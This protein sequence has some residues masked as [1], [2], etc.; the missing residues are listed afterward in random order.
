LEEDAQGQRYEAAAYYYFSRLLAD[1]RSQ[2]G[3]AHTAFVEAFLQRHTAS[4][5]ESSAPSRHDSAMQEALKAVT[6]LCKSIEVV[7]GGDQGA[8]AIETLQ[9]WLHSSVERCVFAHVG[10]TVWNLYEARFASDDNTYSRKMQVLAR[11]SPEQV[12]YQLGVREALSPLRNDAGSL[13]SQPFARATY[14][15]SR[16]GSSLRSACHP[17]PGEVAQLVSAVVLEMR[18]GALAA[19]RGASEL[20]AMD[21]VLPLFAFVLSRSEL[22]CPFALAAYAEDALSSEARLGADCW[23]VRLLESAARHLAYELESG[24]SDDCCS[25]NIEAAPTI[26]SCDAAGESRE[27]CENKVLTDGD[28]SVRAPKDRSHGS[29]EHESVL[30]DSPIAAAQLCMMDCEK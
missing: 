30:R 8:A 21:D 16:L 11:E 10:N 24:R 13:T 17:S 14:A 1:E 4:G 23:A 28:S 15:L 27:H 9:P 19:T 26:T 22:P 2:L 18:T 7:V 6:G 20:L 5:E 12:I 29:T 25:N 3:L